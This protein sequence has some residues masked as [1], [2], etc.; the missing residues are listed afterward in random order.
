MELGRC[1]VTNQGLLTYFWHSNEESVS[2]FTVV[3]VWLP[4]LDVPSIAQ[5]A[6][7]SESPAFF[8]P[9][10]KIE[11]S[12]KEQRNELITEGGLTAGHGESP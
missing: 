7:S 4:T 8:C 1:R 3:R 6:T 11:T 2:A 5:R 9:A 12:A 10:Q